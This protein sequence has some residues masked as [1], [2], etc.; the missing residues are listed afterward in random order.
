MLALGMSGDSDSASYAPLLVGQS[1]VLRGEDEQKALGAAYAGA[2][3]AGSV[4]DSGNSAHS[5]L[6]LQG[7]LGA[8]KTTFCSGLLAA[9][10]FEDIV[11]SPTYSLMHAYPTPHGQVLHVD[12]YRL[13][14]SAELYEMGL[15]ELLDDSLLCLIEWGQLFY[16]DY[17]TAAIL[18]FEYLEHT[19]EQAKARR[20]SR[21][22]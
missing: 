11:S 6:F 22:R 9:L 5:V 12:A 16:D 15:D 3:L 20:V 13:S 19:P 21:L 10:D 14:H 2:A 18:Q 1:L 4:K 17:L 7:E 8:G